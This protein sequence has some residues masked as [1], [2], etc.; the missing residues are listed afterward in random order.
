MSKNRIVSK[1]DL[2]SFLS[3]VLLLCS[4][5]L[6]FS[7]VYKNTNGFSEKLSYRTITYKDKTYSSNS[8][9][10][11]D[12]VNVGEY[13]FKINDYI[14]TTGQESLNYDVAIY[15]YA[16]SDTDFT[17]SI[18][19]KDYKYS[20]L[21]DNFSSFFK[22]NKIGDSFSISLSQGFSCLGMLESV[23][24]NV[25]FVDENSELFFVKMV[26]SFE[27]SSNSIEIILSFGCSIKL[28]DTRLVF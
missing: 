13:V 7:F 5:L 1:N 27:D 26:V 9:N 24:D 28:S 23:Y 22:L 14:G 3:I 12:C 8:V 2:A 4:F 15:P 21:P 19:G 25:K 16:T 20:T 17:I 11:L 18:D 10:N 6:V